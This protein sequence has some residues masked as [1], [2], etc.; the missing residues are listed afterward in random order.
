MSTSNIKIN[1]KRKEIL[2]DF[3]KKYNLKFNNINLLNQAFIHTS[4]TNENNL[5]VQM[6][7][8][9]LE[10]MGDAVLKLSVSEF[11]YENFKNYKE[12]ELTKLRAEIVSDNNI[13]NYAKKIGLKDLIMLGENEKKQGGGDKS[14]ILA[15]SFEAL[16][17]AI[18]LENKEMGYKTA[19]EFLRKNFIDD[20]LNIEKNIGYLNPKAILQEYTQSLNCKLPDYTLIKE[21]GQA[22]NKTF[23]VEVSFENKILGKGQG[24]TIK[25]AE[26]NAAYEALIK[27]KVIT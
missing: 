17:G 19:K 13:A 18:L 3:Q 24:K 11:L 23:F 25:K 4:Y 7:Y 2:E 16:L 15:C 20:I 22:H 27:L 6:S 14:S 10:F 9:K 26:A 1:S 21:E 5:D 8:E 12:G